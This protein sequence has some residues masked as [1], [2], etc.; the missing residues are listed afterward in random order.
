MECWCMGDQY[1]KDKR[2]RLSQKNTCIVKRKGVF[3]DCTRT[4]C[5]KCLDKHL[6]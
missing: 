4:K 2:E 1:Y 6:K 3:V 5:D